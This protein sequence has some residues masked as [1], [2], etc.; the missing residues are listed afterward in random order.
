MAKPVIRMPKINLILSSVRK[1]FHF[2]DG[3]V[4]FVLF[5]E[6]SSFSLIFSAIT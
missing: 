6:G 2:P 4:V 5:F 3:L 1:D